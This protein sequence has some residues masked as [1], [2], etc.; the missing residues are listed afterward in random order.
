[1]KARDVLAF[2]RQHALTL[3][4]EEGFRFGSPDIEVTGILVAWMA[5]VEAIEAARA[6]RCNLLIV[7]E[8]ILFPPEYTHTRP[9]PYLSGVV[10]TRRLQR[11]AQE[12]MAVIRAHGS[13]D[14]LCILDDFAATL[15]LPSPAVR[16][17]Y[18]RVYDIAPTRVDVLAE[19]IKARLALPSLRLVG[20]ATRVV[21]RVGLPWGGLGLS[22]N[23][24]FIE[25]LLRYHVDVLIAGESDEY[26]LWAARDADV[27]LIETA[28]AVSE[29]PGLRR[30][31]E[32]LGAFVAPIPVVFHAL[33]RPWRLI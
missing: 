33:G 16:E 20:D 17:G 9:E 19:Q 24:A 13:L 18:H 26:A 7:H 28:H 27:P 30:F 1:M 22:Y 12:E 4:E 25:G 6:H 8:D 2:W 3:S 21:R 29:E 5:T 11:L 31:A 15:G 23:A 32:M 10:N 14:R